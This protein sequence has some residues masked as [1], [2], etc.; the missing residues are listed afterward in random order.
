MSIQLQTY[1]INEF[2]ESINKIKTQISENLIILRNNKINKIIKL[3]S[4]YINEKEAYAICIHFGYCFQYN[5]LA[6]PEFEKLC[7]LT[8]DGFVKK[9]II[10]KECDKIKKNDEIK[11]IIRNLI[12][13]DYLWCQLITESDRITFKNTLLALQVFNRFANDYKIRVKDAIT[14]FQE[15]LN[16]Y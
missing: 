14:V 8:F 1:N 7:E 5:I 2:N 4:N 3:T 15:Y 12:L 10:I 6:M 11:E 16:T 9:F 13:Q